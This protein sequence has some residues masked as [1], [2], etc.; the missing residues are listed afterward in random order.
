MY[1]E[2]FP[3][4]FQRFVHTY[5][6]HIAPAST[7]NMRLVGGTGVGVGCGG[8]GQCSTITVRIWLPGRGEVEGEEVEMEVYANKVEQH[9]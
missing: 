7:S 4:Q 6:K 3:S 9:L 5:K 2:M 1:R 8:L